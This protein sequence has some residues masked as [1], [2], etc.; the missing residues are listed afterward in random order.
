MNIPDISI[1]MPMR[2][3]EKYIE[4]TVKSILRQIFTNFE[5]LALNDGS[6]DKTLILLSNFN[7]P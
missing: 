5:L 2:N 4:N 1:L 3:T 6:T 7:D